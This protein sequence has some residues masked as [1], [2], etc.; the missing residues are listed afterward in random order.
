MPVQGIDFI[1]A[2]ITQCE[3]RV[4]GGQTGPAAK[5]LGAWALGTPQASDAFGAFPSLPSVDERRDIASA[6]AVV[7]VYDA[8]IGGAGIH[9]AEK[10]G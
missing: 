4:I 1:T 10:S 7:D 8:D 6:E 3:G 9:H 5:T 2:D